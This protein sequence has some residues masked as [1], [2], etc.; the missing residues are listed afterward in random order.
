MPA[1]QARRGGAEYVNTYTPT[2]GHDLRKP[3]GQR[4]IETFAP[5]T[6]AAPVHANATGEAAMATA[7]EG[8]L[9]GH[10]RRH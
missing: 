7:V 10:G 2:V 9:S 6:P 1:R 8:V 3:I 4:W 5:E